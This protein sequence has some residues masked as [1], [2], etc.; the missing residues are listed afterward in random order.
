[1]AAKRAHF[2]ERP[3]LHTMDWKDFVA[4]GVGG[5]LRFRSKFL[6]SRNSSKFSM[7]FPDF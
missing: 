7:V 4:G 2:R 3:F 5:A 6:G 1:M